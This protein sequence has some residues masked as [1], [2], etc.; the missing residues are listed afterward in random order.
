MKVYNENK[1]KILTDVNTNLGRLEPDTIVTGHHDAVPATPEVT[2]KEI[3]DKIVANGGA[4]T[5][6]GGKWYEILQ[7]YDFGMDVHLIEPIPAVPAKEAYD[8]Y[9]DIYVFVPY[10][11]EELVEIERE[12]IR[13][14]R[15]TE[16]FA[17]VNRGKLW[18]DKLSVER[19]TE[20]ADWYEAWLN[21]PETLVVPDRPEWIDN[22]LNTEEA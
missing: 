6:I 3:A 15:V 16:C 18:Y 10:T 17:I 5:Q 20:L 1:T 14:R 2:V 12:R 11:K 13:T 21:A 22:K 4:V 7:K 8:E 19:E 9:E